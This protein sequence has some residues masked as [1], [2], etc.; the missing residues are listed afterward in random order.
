MSDLAPDAYDMETEEGQETEPRGFDITTAPQSPNLAFDIDDTVLAAMGSKVVEEY[1]IDD[2]SRKEAGYDERIK[3][4][5]ELATLAKEA[6]NY[7]WPDASNVKYPLIIQACIQF[8]ARSY[9]AVID[10]PSLVKGRVLGK[11]SPEKQA[12][13]Q[14]VAAHMSWQ[15]LEQEEEW[16]EDTDHLLLRL[17]I[18]G[19]MVRKRYFDPGLGRN[20]S[21]LIA[22]DEFVV[23]Y[24]AKRD[25]SV[26]PRATHVLTFCPQEIIEKKRAGLWL[27]VELGE[28]DSRDEQAPHTFLEQH[29]LW[30]LDEDGYPEPYIVTVH[31]ET[32]KVVR[33]MARWYEDGIKLNDRGEVA[34]IT[35]YRCFTKYGFIPSSDGSFYDMGFGTLLGPLSATIDTSINQLMDAAHLANVQGGF[36]G[37]GVSIKSGNLRF[38]PG[39]WKKVGAAGG[40]LKDSIVP[41]PV[42]EPSAVL[43]N[44]MVFLIDAAKE[45]TATQDILTGDTGKST[46]PVGTT[47]ALIE[48]GLK[49]FTA[50]VKRIHRALKKE[51]AVQYQ[52]NAR[53]LNEEEHFTFQDEEQQ[54][55]REDYALG[56]LDV[57]PVS[58][59]SMATDM[60]KMGRAQF[61]LG[62][63]GAGLNDME[64]NRRALEAASIQDVPALM[65]EGP[66]PPDPKIA[67]ENR[68]LDQK[69]TELQIK[70]NEAAAGIAEQEARIAKLVADT[71]QTTLA[72]LMMGP[73]F[74]L[75]AIQASTQATAALTGKTEDGGQVQQPDVPGMA[76]Q[77]PDAGLPP[78]PEGPAIGPEGQMG[79]GPG[80]GFPAP[81]QGSPDGGIGQP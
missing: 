69:D 30:D 74:Q 56:D 55:G 65:P 75:A 48:Q 17:P 4:A 67:L 43:Y 15:L 6:K 51:L 7:P 68:K 26:C 66:P 34:K 22:P 35:P 42:K 12:R 20:T 27:D 52:L 49:T 38:R 39:E 71:M 73:E 80:N 31:K 53:Y 61:L 60:Q 64:I 77:P 16:E 62:M 37:E 58:D 76:Q 29:R 45:L 57:V 2:A 78:V 5:V 50:I 40:S 21:V 70:D 41:M 23:N 47:L 9:P 59:P 25:L 1:G 46:M 63:R 10:G 24:R 72:T 81:D 28:A 54:T 18:V 11:P 19:T 44:L 33:V 36:I 3:Q 13:A 8:N 32:E 14:R 79:V